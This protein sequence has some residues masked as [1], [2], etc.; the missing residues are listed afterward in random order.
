ML[1][2]VVSASDLDTLR[3]FA[4]RVRT[5]AEKIVANCVRG[6]GFE[7]FLPLYRR[8]RRW[9][10]RMK[11]VESPLFPGYLFCRLNPLRRLPLLTVPGVMHVVGIGKIPAPI[12]DHEIAAI[13]AAMRSGLL[14]E[15]HYFLQVGERVRL[16][17]GPLAGLEGVLVKV[18]GQHRIVVSVTLLQRSVSVEI[19]RNWVAPVDAMRSPVVAIHRAILARSPAPGLVS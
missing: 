15:P 2:D 17:D 7:E 10:D 19:D 14:I 5:G 4:L 9:S 18:R 16:D 8:R 3:W 1:T 6:K 13:Q 11:N 12:H